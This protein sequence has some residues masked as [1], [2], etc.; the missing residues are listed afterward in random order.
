MKQDLLKGLSEEQIRKVKE[1]KNSDELLK[2]AREENVE[3]ND[4]QLEAV[5]G[6]GCGSTIKCPNCG[7]KDF[8]RYEKFSDVGSNLTTEYKCKK[9]GKR[10][11]D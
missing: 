2:L 1:C 11:L 6:G 7:S 8:I 10:W 3:L 5:N 9:C 4:E